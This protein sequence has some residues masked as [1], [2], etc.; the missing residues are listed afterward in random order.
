MVAQ[1]GRAGRACFR[2]ATERA[3]GGD[4][5][6]RA[7]LGQDAARE[8]ARV[9]VKKCQRRSSVTCVQ[10]GDSGPHQAR[11]GFQGGRRSGRGGDP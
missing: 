3:Q 5:F 2:F 1:E 9:L 11:F 10:R 6:G 4:S 8:F 7:F